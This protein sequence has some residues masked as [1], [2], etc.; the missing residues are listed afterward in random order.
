[1]KSLTICYITCRPEPRFD[2]FM[3]SLAAQWPDERIVQVIIIDSLKSSRGCDLSAGN[4]IHAKPK[5]TVWQGKNR[6]TQSDWWAASNARNTGICLCRT[7]WIA[8][9]DDRSVLVPGWM[10][11]IRRAMEGNYAVAGAYEKVHNLVVENG[12]IKSYTEPANDGNPTGRDSRD[13]G[14]RDPERCH[15]NWWFG[16]TN[17]LPLE[18]AL[19]VNGYDETCDS[20]GMED[21]I[22][23]AMLENSGLPIRYDPRMKIVEDRTPGSIEY[24]AKRTDKG[25]SPNDKSHAL[26]H[27][28]QGLS[29][30]AHNW[31]LREVRDKV[32]SGEPFPVPRGPT[33]DWWDNQPLSEFE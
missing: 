30:A 20:L 12:M 19:Q 29:R 5:P 13:S 22:F 6:L 31:D 23:G 7:E 18:W 21:V 9:V 11:S 1:M 14:Q 16:C 25:K 24:V 3:D 28:L 33:H 26:L 32:L 4:I 8:F 2:W 27:K 10:E 15:G 17:A